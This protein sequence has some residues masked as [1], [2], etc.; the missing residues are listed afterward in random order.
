MAKHT[1][2]ELLKKAQDDYGIV[3]KELAERSGIGVQHLASIRTGKAWPSEEVLIRILDAM[4][5]LAPGSRDYFCAL[6][7]G[8]NISEVE[9][10]VEH[11]DYRDLSSLLCLAAKRLRELDETPENSVHTDFLSVG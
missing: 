3:G 2:R 10:L 11:M 4:D 7:A 1:I 6:L 9:F 5:E 8:K